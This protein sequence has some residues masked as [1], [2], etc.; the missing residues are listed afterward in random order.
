MSGVHL[1]VNPGGRPPDESPST[2]W[3]PSLERATSPTLM[4]DQPVQKRNKTNMCGLNANEAFEMEADGVD[5]AQRQLSKGIP[6][7]QSVGINGESV[8]NGVE[9]ETYASMA[10]KKV[11]PDKL[12]NGTATIFDDEVLIMEEDIIVDKSGV[13]PS[14]QFSDRVVYGHTREVCPKSVAANIEGA[15]VDIVV[16]NSEENSI[17]EANLFR[18]WM[19]VWNRRR[20]VDMVGTS[21]DC[22]MVVAKIVEGSRFSVLEDDGETRQEQMVDG[23]AVEMDRHHVSHGVSIP[24]PTVINKAQIKRNEAY[25]STPERRPKT[26]SASARAPTVVPL[27]ETRWLM[28][29]LIHLRSVEDPMAQYVFMSKG[30]GLM[31]ATVGVSK[32]VVDMFGELDRFDG[33]VGGGDDFTHMLSN[34]DSSWVESQFEEDT[35]VACHNSE[36]E[37][38]VQ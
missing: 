27:M 17:S 21:T 34:D 32:F 29:Y 31:S 30:R 8:V 2:Q 3:G 19:Q 23:G 16:G 35:K 26:W 25:M 12:A 7:D 13:I 11:Y 24:R 5:M 14:I 28:L 20:R 15:T 36:R 33:L 37:L 1:S 22:T 38:G 6:G 9:K 4:G 10:A 18:P